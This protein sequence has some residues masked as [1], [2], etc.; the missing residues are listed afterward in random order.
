MQP[1]QVPYSELETFGDLLKYLRRRARLSQLELSIQVGYSESQI[2]RLES[3]QRVPDKTSLLAVFVPALHLENE[4]ET[5]QR[6]VEA[7]DRARPGAEQSR[8]AVGRENPSLNASNA[9]GDGSPQSGSK[10]YN[11]HLPPQLTSFIGREKDIEDVCAL[12][13]SRQVHLVTLTGEGGC[14]KTRLSL[15]VGEALAGE[16]EHGVWLVELA[17]L[18]QPKQVAQAVLTVFGLAENDGNILAHVLEYLSAR[19][20]LLILDNCEHLIDAAADL[21]HQV[22]RGCPGVRILATS[23]EMFGLPGEEIFRVLPLSLPSLRVGDAPHRGDIESF[24]A[25]QLFV[26]RARS[27]ERNFTL[28]DQNAPAVT[29]ICQRLDGIPLAIELAAARMNLLRPEQIASRLEADFDLLTGR[30]RGE[31][32]HHSTLKATIDWSYRLLSQPERLLLARLS[33]FNGGWT[34][35]A[36]DQMA[37]IAP[38][39]SGQA[40]N[41]LSELVNKS[42]V[43]VDL[44]AEGEARYRMLETVQSYLHARLVENNEEQLARN[45]HLRYA[46]SLSSQAEPGLQGPDQRQWL[47]RLSKEREN[48]RSAFAWCLKSGQLEMGLQ[49]AGDLYYFWWMTGNELEGNE[50]SRTFLKATE[51]DPALQRSRKTAKVLLWYGLLGGDERGR[52]LILAE[53]LSIYQELRDPAGCGMALCW[54]GALN[55]DLQKGAED[56]QQA[57]HY[58]YQAEDSWWIAETLH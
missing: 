52:S 43:T 13:G 42:L 7:A 57:L 33:V 4:P 10:S 41:L 28:N 19:Q 47:N 40:L 56:L 5:I 22:L 2:S 17:P 44:S 48:F 1:H 26:E 58:C 20:V 29:R 38:L 16:F 23:R 6:L 54:I 24:E 45:C 9:P 55:P 35:D 25:I 49:M 11:H 34:L 53:S 37:G 21:A 39:A 31:L 12:L 3:N 18:S 8:R 46:V 32:P 30:L 50:W 14:G 15:R 51:A 27:V 36:A